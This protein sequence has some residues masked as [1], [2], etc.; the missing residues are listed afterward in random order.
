MNRLSKFLTRIEDA[1]I[2]ISYAALIVFVGLETVRRMLTNDQAIWGPEL[3]MYAF[4]WLSW[5][6][7]SSHVRNNTNLAF[8]AFRERLAAKWKVR[9]EALDLCMWLT[10]GLIIIVESVQLV[11][12]NIV[13]KQIVFGTSIP[14]WVATV[15]IPIA[16]GFTMVGIAQRLVGLYRGV[17]PR[18]V[19]G[20]STA[21]DLPPVLI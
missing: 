3:A 16:W 12:T 13:M 1:V 11:H 7:M 6:S 17:D 10:I 20:G 15:A 4:I 18:T 2:L 21:G 8:S 9:L 19:E 14:L 5:F